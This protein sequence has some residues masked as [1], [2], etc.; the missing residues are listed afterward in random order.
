VRRPQIF[1]FPVGEDFPL[2]RF[3]QREE[4]T[5][6]TLSRSVPYVD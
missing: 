1:D 3:I 4:E 5:P 2:I 6:R